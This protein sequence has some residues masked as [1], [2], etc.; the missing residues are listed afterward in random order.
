MLWAG[1]NP[2]GDFQGDRMRTDGLETAE[3]GV[4]EKK[5]VAEKSDRDLEPDHCVPGGCAKGPS[6][7]KVEAVPAP[8]LQ[9]RK[10]RLGRFS[11]DLL[12]VPSQWSRDPKPVPRSSSSS[13]PSTVMLS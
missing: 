10:A 2:I 3:E 5:K 1:E 6:P 9:K 11:S 8:I 4:K 12:K 7:Q 13:I